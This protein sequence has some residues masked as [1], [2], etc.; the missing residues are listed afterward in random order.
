[1]DQRAAPI[2]V[3]QQFSKP[4]HQVWEAITDPEQMV[5]WFFNNIPDFKAEVGFETT[6]D[7]DSGQ[8]IFVHLWK[9][10]EIIYP[11]KIVYHWSYRGIEGA[12]KVIFDL[13]ENKGGT[14]LRVTNEGLHTFPDDIP[15]FARESCVG[16]WKY[17][18]NGNLKQYLDGD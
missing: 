14:M 6:F 3:E 12:G 7:V 2:V 10:T 1:M 5:R 16:G 4:V 17:F 11:S 15:E 13:V 9:I 18:I 8:R